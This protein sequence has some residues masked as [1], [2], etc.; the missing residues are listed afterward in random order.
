MT[1][2]CTLADA[3]V[4]AKAT[5]TND[6]AKLRREIYRVSKRIDAEM[7]SPRRPFFAPYTEQR[8]YLVSGSRVDSYNN[9]FLMNDPILSLTAVTRAGETITSTTALYQPD[10]RVADSLR[11]TNFASSWYDCGSSTDVPPYFVLVTGIWGWHED[12][13][14]AY[15]AVDVVA[16]A[17]GITSSG[18]SITVADADGADLD[19][20][21][22]RFSPGNL[23]KIGTELMDVTAVNTTT[24]VLTVRR[25]VNGTTAAAHALNAAISVYRVDERIRH[26]TA[27]QSAFLYARLGAFQ[28]QSADGLSTIT[29]P[30]DL[31]SELK[32]VLREFQYA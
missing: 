2:Y 28:T 21:T 7:G 5:T 15:D 29:Y 1:L 13:A 16:D 3:K 12:Y 22:P 20:F 24:N 26:V 4:E 30:E 6:D 9:T 11:I 32:G 8:R 19:G 18:T 27:R 23:I 14:N 17:G 10:N 25:A 31:L